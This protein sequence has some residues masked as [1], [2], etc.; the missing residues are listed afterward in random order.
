MTFNPDPSIAVRDPDYFYNNLEKPEFKPAPNNNGGGT[1]G[2]GGSGS[3][4]GGS[5]SNG[6]GQPQPVG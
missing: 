2:S 5:G 3:N 6:G 4:N 1:G